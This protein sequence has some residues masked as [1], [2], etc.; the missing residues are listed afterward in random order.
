[1]RARWTACTRSCARCGPPARPWPWSPAGASPRCCASA[2]SRPCRASSSTAPTAR[3]GGRRARCA[4]RRP[5]P[6]W[7]SCARA[8]RGSWPAS[9]PISGWKTR[10]C[11]W[12]CTRASPL[13]PTACWRCCTLR[14]SEAAAAAGLGVRP[15]REVLEICIPGIDKGTAIRELVSEDTAAAFYAGDDLGDLP[16]IGEVNAWAERT[17]R[18]ALTVA[19]GRGPGR[20]AGRRHRAGPAG[21]AVAAAADPPTAR[22]SDSSER[23]TDVHA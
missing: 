10:A 16:A 12:S 15:G 4:P 11:R 22:S 6:A 13:T 8:C 5:R 14:S 2:A 7:T 17:G 23:S 3:N 1:M 19:V 21:P 20:R 18:P 9:D